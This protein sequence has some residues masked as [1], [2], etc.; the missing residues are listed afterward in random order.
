[1]AR[2]GE[3]YVT[4]RGAAAGDRAATPPGLGLGFFIAKTL[5]ERSGATLTLAQ[6]RLPAAR[7]DR[8]AH[9]GAA[10]DFER[11]RTRVADREREA[12]ASERGLRSDYLWGR[13]SMRINPERIVLGSIPVRPRRPGSGRTGFA[14]LGA[15]VSWTRSRTPSSRATARC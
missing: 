2:I 8:A 7:R 13:I 15:G 3:P 10:S 6:P 5:L 14:D 1:M 11:P 9:A 4:S 12:A